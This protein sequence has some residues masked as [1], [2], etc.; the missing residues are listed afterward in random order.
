MN[1]HSCGICFS[2]QVNLQLFDVFSLSDAFV[3]QYVVAKAALGDGLGQ[4]Q[5]GRGSGNLHGPGPAG[6]GRGR[7]VHLK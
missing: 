6:D 3:V 2:L 7:G 4:R 5:N 1:L